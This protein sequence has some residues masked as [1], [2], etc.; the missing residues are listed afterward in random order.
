MTTNLVV[1][2]GFDPN[3]EGQI[4]PILEAR[5]KDSIRIC[6]ENPG[7]MLLLMGSHTFRAKGPNGN[8]R[9]GSKTFFRH[10]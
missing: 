1:F 2:L 8:C 10:G 9:K 4:L 7:S 5:L 6:K 3:D